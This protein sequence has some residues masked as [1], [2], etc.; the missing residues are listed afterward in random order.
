M[1]GNCTAGNA[2]LN[3]NR[4]VAF[5]TPPMAVKNG[6]KCQFFHKE[7]GSPKQS[8]G[9]GKGKKKKSKKKGKGKGDSDSGPESSVCS[10]EEDW[11]STAAPVDNPYRNQ[12][13]E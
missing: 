10:E 1:K 7:K 5:T 4:N 6:D 12:Q 8:S 3:T 9:K 2:D 11:L 13:R